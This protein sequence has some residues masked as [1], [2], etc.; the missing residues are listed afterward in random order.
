ME[1]NN[2]RYTESLERLTE[3]YKLKY[4]IKMK[5]AVQM[6]VTNAIKGQEHL[7]RKA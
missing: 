1:K 2:T 7:N 5:G 4:N 6:L 3:K